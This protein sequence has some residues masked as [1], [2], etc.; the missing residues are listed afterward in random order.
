MHT[1]LFF[2]FLWVAEDTKISRFRA[3]SK[4]CNQVLTGVVIH[5]CT[6]GTLATLACLEHVASAG[7]IDIFEV[8]TKI[9]ERTVLASFPG[10]GTRLRTVHTGDYGGWLTICHSSVGEY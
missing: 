10:L 3:K 2:L 7:K 6:P 4:N 5:Q 8:E 1:T 9:E